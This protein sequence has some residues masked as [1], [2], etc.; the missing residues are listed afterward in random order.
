MASSA[1]IFARERVEKILGRRGRQ[2]DREP[3]RVQCAQ[4]LGT[5][6][7]DKDFGKQLVEVR[8]PRPCD[9]VVAATDEGLE[10]L[11]RAHP[12]EAMDCRQPGVAAMVSERAR[13]RHR[14]V[15][16]AIDERA[17][18]VDEYCGAA[19]AVSLPD[20]GFCQSPEPGSGGLGRS[21]CPSPETA[22]D[23]LGGSRGQHG[24]CERRSNQR[25]AQHDGAPLR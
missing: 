7:D 22:N 13:P 23:D 4:Q 11:R 10:Q 3:A 24:S 17:V 1:S 2:H 19:H 14:V 21:R 8:P 20:A 16:V 5:A 6:V 18:D 25:N 15:I 12:D 9:L